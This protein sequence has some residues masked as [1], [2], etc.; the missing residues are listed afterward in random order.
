MPICSSD[1]KLYTGAGHEPD[2]AYGEP[3]L[4]IGRADRYLHCKVLPASTARRGVKLV[5]D[6]VEDRPGQ[7]TDVGGSGDNAWA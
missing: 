7:V 5:G 2:L 3:G 6:V 4:L 1:T